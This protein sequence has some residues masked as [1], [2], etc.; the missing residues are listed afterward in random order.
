MAGEMFMPDFPIIDAHVH[1][2]DVEKLNYSWMPNVPS[3][4]HTSLVK[5]FDQARGKVDVDGIVFVEVDIDPGLHI[6]EAKFV[7]GLAEG[8]KRLSAIV[9]HAPLEKG[10]AIEADLEKLQHIKGVKGIRRLIQGEVDPS[11]C[12][13]PDFVDAVNLLPK[14]GMS[15]DICIRHYQLVYAIEL[16][17][18]CPNVRFILDHIA[19]PD[20]KNGLMEPW[21]SQ[22][23]EMAK[24][25]N[26]VCKVSG[27][28]TEADHQAWTRQQ[29]R[30]YIEHVIESFGFDRVMFGSDWTVATLALEY[31]TWVDILDEVLAGTSVD[32]KRH[33]WRGTAI[34][35]YKLPFLV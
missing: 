13:A 8:D 2:Y 20:I 7:A 12:I 29:L 24:L 33:F 10:L 5:E 3:L 28:A 11:M 4:N 21:K 25:P 9:A 32:E 14:Y 18:K 26:V 34:E 15:F 17:K 35:A 30:P 23:L 22:I 6:E 27:V 31:P 19:K 16:I 1:F